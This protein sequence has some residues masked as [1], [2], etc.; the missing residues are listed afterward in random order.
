MFGDY[1][2]NI[3]DYVVDFDK[4]KCQCGKWQ[5]YQYPCIDAIAVI[6]MVYQKDIE[7]VYSNYVCNFFKY[8]S[9][10]EVLN[11]NII[12]INVHNLV[13]DGKTQPPMKNMNKSSGRPKTDIRLRASKY[14]GDEKSPIVCSICK[15]L[16][17]NKC[18]CEICQIM[19]LKRSNPNEET[20]NN[21]FGT[22][23][24]QHDIL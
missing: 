11:W 23:Y 15:Q 8:E 14:K 6:Y 18:T 4:K 5:D 22:Y 3:H 16:G 17:H 7:F 10:H 1:E 21:V 24:P 13:P 20:N 12:P 2:L 9:I 19:E